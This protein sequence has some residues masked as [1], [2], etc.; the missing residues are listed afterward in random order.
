MRKLDVSNGNDSI[1]VRYLGWALRNF[2][3]WGSGRWGRKR[4]Q[5]AMGIPAFMPDSGP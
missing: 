2:I 3:D 4:I 5:T 1:F